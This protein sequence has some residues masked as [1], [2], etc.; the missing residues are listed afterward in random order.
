MSD[1][2]FKY[3]RKEAIEDGVLIDLSE[4]AA[5]AGIKFP[6]AI[7]AGVNAVLNNLEVTGQDF[8]GRAWDMLTIFKLGIRSSKGDRF[9]FTPL[10]ASKAANGRIV[11]KPIDMWSQCG[12][13]DNL[14]PVI[15]IMLKGED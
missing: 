2:I 1:V 7:T 10:F 3:T 5:E 8:Q 4:M 11:T 12:P 15:T 9:N 13:G 14:E 6:V